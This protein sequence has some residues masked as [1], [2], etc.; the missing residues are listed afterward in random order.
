MRYLYNQDQLVASFVA[1]MIPTMRRGFG[2]CRAIGVLDANNEL[3]AGLVYHN[4]VPDAGV[5]ELSAAALPGVPWLTRKTI[6]VMFHYPFVQCGCQ[7]LLQ[8]TPADDERTLRQLAA[9]N[10]AFVTVPRLLGRDRDGVLCLLTYEA[11]CNSRFSKR[12][13]VVRDVSRDTIGK[14]A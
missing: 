14:A 2:A 9:G 6:E 1:A 7:L 12:L 4:M 11:W 3:V 5:I 8:L 10:Y 13:Q